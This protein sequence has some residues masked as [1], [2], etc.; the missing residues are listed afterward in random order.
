MR[1][2]R[3]STRGEPACERPD[4]AER[5]PDWPDLS[6]AERAALEAHA[7]ACAECGTALELVRGADAW[8]E[9]QVPASSPNLCP[10]P[11]ELYDYGRG[12]GARPLPEVERVAL[13]AH[14]AECR[15]CSGMVETLKLRPPAPLL[16]LPTP[17]AGAFSPELTSVAPAAT[18]VHAPSRRAPSRRA[19][20]RLR[21]LAP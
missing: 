2:R 10:S 3:G 8:L 11:E 5:L 21:L 6:A 9:E 12:P 4:L 15:E 13:R 17:S 16:D 19:P 18:A 1:A 20:M 14:L 7:L